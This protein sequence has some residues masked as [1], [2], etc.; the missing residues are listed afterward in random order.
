MREPALTTEAHAF[1][2]EAGAEVVALEYPAHAFVRGAEERA[3]YRSR[4]ASRANEG[5]ALHFDP[6]TQIAILPHGSG[7]DHARCG[8]LRP[9]L[10]IGKVHYA[11]ERGQFEGQVGPAADGF[12]RAA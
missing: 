7:S 6:V 11:G 5:I 10:E 8:V 9:L 3:G 1:A 12:R 2:A 4:I